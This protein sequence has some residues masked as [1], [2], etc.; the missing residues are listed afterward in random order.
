MKPPRTLLIIPALLLAGCQTPAAGVT[1][2]TFSYRCDDGR[3]SPESGRALVQ[4]SGCDVQVTMNVEIN[5]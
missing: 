4:G 5:M 2:K 3:D 1:A